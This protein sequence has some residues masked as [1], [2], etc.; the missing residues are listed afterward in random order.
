MVYFAF[1]KYLPSEPHWR[2]ILA[3]PDAETID[4][5]WREASANKDND[6]KR[7][8]PDF[9]SWNNT[10]KN[11]WDL[12][13][14]FKDRIIY[15]LL[16]DT[17]HRNIPTFHQ[18]KRADVTSGQSFYIRSKSNP[19]L[20]WLAK[21]DQ[22]W[23]TTQGRTRFVF[24]IDGD[25]DDK[26]TVL[27]GSDQISIAPVGGESSQKYVSVSD[28]SEIVLSGHSC[29]MYFRDLK[30]NFLAQGETGSSGSALVTKVEG[31]G[32]EWE[33]IQ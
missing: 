1:L 29:R 32:E 13:P 28:N 12:A 21:N 19:E 18:P 23:A 7:L 8:S 16:S 25:H 6:V 30:T 26:K 27:I 4:E 15:S 17:G 9:Y 11:A 20:Y 31:H 24:R 5:W 22:I 33:L 3:A 10:G 14:E 2:Y